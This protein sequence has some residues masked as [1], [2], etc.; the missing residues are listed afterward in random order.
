M[1][2]LNEEYT[3]SDEEMRLIPLRFKEARKKLGLNQKQLADALGVSRPHIS[4]IE[5]GNDRPSKTLIA[6]FILRFNIRE[7]WLLH[8]EGYMQPNY[9]LKKYESLA[10]RYTES[11]ELLESIVNEQN[12][13]QLR[14]IIIAF[15]SFVNILRAKDIPDE[16]KPKYRS[17]FYNFM[18][19]VDT[20]LLIAQNLR[21]TYLHDP[22]WKNAEDLPAEARKCELDM[23][24]NGTALISMVRMY[25]TIIHD[26]EVD[27]L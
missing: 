23:E 15:S 4:N 9:T 24:E 22:Y 17:V 6:L 26:D 10:K 5:N 2:I 21:D 19:G 8:G 12:D 7:A 18:L 20:E 3:F 14:E 25:T 1:N 11:K 13:E 27:A 16:Q